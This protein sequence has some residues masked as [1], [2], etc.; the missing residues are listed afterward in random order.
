MHSFLAFSYRL[1]S[2]TRITKASARGIGRSDGS[3][4]AT[5]ASLSD[6]AL[7][8]VCIISSDSSVTYDTG[9]SLDQIPLTVNTEPLVV[10]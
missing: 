5:P 8:K 1:R 4:G 2:P 6:A 9:H 7:S 10:R 3:V